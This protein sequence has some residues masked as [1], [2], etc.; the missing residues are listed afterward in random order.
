M[1]N[2]LRPS[3]IETWGSGIG[4]IQKLCKE[5]S[6]KFEINESG[7]FVSIV[8]HRLQKI[9]VGEKMPNSAEKILNY[10]EKIIVDFLQ[11]NQKIDIYTAQKLLDIKERRTRE[12]LSNLVKK[13]ILE[14][15]GKTKGSFYI[16]KG[17]K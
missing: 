5:N 1:H 8:F 3:S 14:K 6:I 15:I 10:Q 11:K 7:N 17:I 2:F 12:I 4:K 9:I 13:N 16:L